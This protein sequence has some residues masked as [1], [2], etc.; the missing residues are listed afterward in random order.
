MKMRKFECCAGNESAQKQKNFKFMYYFVIE[1]KS[2]K[3]KPENR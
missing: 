1:M 2:E 3:K